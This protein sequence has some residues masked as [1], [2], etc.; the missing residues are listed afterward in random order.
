MHELQIKADR[1]QRN[2]SSPAPLLQEEDTIISSLDDQMNHKNKK[3]N[4]HVKVVR[5][6]EARGSECSCKHFFP[7]RTRW[8]T[9]SFSGNQTK[10]PTD[11]I[12]RQQQ[13][14]TWAARDY[15]TIVNVILLLL[16]LFLLLLVLFLFLPLS[17][18]IL[19]LLLLLLHHD[20]LLSLLLSH[21]MGFL[22]GV[23]FFLVKLETP[24]QH[25][26]HSALVMI[27]LEGSGSE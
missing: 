1:G 5:L 6:Q 14:Q 9:D 22:S 24:T 16:L 12:D 10:Q 20:Q 8:Q 26:H 25:R 7:T 27:M 23:F 18:V 19:Q 17:V 21:Q 11:H 15:N 13:Q 4:Q 3:H 2:S